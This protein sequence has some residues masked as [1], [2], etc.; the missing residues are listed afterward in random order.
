M[1]SGSTDPGVRSGPRFLSSPLDGFIIMFISTPTSSIIIIVIFISIPTLTS[2][3]KSPLGILSVI[4][5]VIPHL[6]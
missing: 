4:G 5:L 2:V 6:L 3:S 1:Q